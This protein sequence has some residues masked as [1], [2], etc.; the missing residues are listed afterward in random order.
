M[1]VIVYPYCE[2]SWFFNVFYYI[3]PSMLFALRSEQSLIS[4]TTVWWFWFFRVFSCFLLFQLQLK[5]KEHGTRVLFLVVLR[6][7]LRWKQ[8]AFIA[9]PLWSSRDVFMQLTRNYF[10]LVFWISLLS[11]NI[12]RILRVFNE[13][14]MFSR[15][16]LYISKGSWNKCKTFSKNYSLQNKTN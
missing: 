3:F 12:I 2:S 11:R 10:N 4:R 9:F 1:T 7:A 16:Y 13:L 8:C 6:L 14:V 5:W 15:N